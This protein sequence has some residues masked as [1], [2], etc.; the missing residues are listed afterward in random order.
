MT[1]VVQEVVT[2]TDLES[3]LATIINEAVNLKDFVVG[4]IPETLVQL[5]TWHGV[6]N[7]L[8]CLA[9]VLLIIPIGLLGYKMYHYQT[10]GNGPREVKFV[11]GCM[12]IFITSV[13][14]L[15]HM[16]IIWLQIWIAPRVF[17]IEYAANLLKP[18]VQQ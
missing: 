18:A 16:N 14:S 15:V 6:Y 7:A 1:T 11:F 3:T 13:T 5:L 10:N 8:T 9:A 17:M 2:A 4:E 12:V